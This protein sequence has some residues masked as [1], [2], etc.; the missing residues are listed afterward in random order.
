MDS[1]FQITWGCLSR[2]CPPCISQNKNAEKTALNLTYNE[3]FLPTNKGFVFVFSIGFQHLSSVQLALQM[4]L[5]WIPFNL[6][7]LEEREIYNPWYFVHTLHALSTLCCA[8]L[9]FFSSIFLFFC[10]KM[11]LNA[12]M[13]KEVIVWKSYHFYWLHRNPQWH[14]IFAN[15]PSSKH[16]SH[17]YFVTVVFFLFNVNVVTQTG[18]ASI[19]ILILFQSTESDS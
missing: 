17:S 18:R 2:S 3:V 1:H 14:N 7:S 11:C 19:N 6:S 13:I 9:C 16:F 12:K 4:T 5:I 8:D 10:I 15:S